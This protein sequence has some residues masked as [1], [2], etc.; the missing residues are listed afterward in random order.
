VEWYGRG[1][2]QAHSMMGAA[3]ASAGP[4]ACEES[5]LCNTR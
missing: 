3:G 5:M 4:A 2:V 1:L